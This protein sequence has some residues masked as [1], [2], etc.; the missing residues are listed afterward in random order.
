MQSFC[1]HGSDL[2]LVLNSVLHLG[3]DIYP[4]CIFVQFDLLFFH[5]Y[6]QLHLPIFVINHVILHTPLLLYDKKIQDEI[7]LFWFL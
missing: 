6:P 1:L 5:L 7:V 2:D 4:D 3:D